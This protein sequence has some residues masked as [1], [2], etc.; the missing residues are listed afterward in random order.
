MSDS[1]QNASALEGPQIDEALSKALTACQPDAANPWGVTQEFGAG[2]GGY[3][4]G[5]STLV[6]PLTSDSGVLTIELDATVQQVDVTAPITSLELGGQR[7]G[8]KSATV[9]FV[10]DATGGHAVALPGD[11]YWPDSTPGAIATA[12][13]AITRL[14]LETDLIGRVYART[15]TWGLAT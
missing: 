14:E 9:I 10:Q 1:Y 4:T 13:N 15:T 3:L 2:L 6:V 5:Y 11:W 8:A 12:A 7:P